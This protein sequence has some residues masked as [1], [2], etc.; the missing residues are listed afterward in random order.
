M[1]DYSLISEYNSK[2]NSDEVLFGADSRVLNT[3][4]NEMQE[5]QKEARRQLIQ[6]LAPSGFTVPIEL[7]YETATATTIK[8]LN[9]AEAYV[10]GMRIFIPKGTLIDL[11]DNPTEGIREDLLFLEVWRESANKDSVL[12]EFGGEGLPTVKNYFLSD[13]V[14]EETA[15]RILTKWRLRCIHD[16]DFSAEFQITNSIYPYIGWNDIYTFSKI[17]AKGANRDL[18]APTMIYGREIFRTSKNNSPRNEMWNY[19]TNDPNLWVAGAKNEPESIQRYK[20]VDGLVFG[21]PIARLN[22][23]AKGGIQ[24]EGYKKIHPSTDPTAFKNCVKAIWKDSDKNEINCIECFEGKHKFE[25]NTGGININGSKLKKGT[26]Y[27][28]VFN[29]LEQQIGGYNYGLIYSINYKDNTPVNYVPITRP[30]TPKGMFKL[31][32]EEQK[33]ILSISFYVH[34]GAPNESFVTVE[35]L[36]ILEGDWTGQDI[37][38]D[39]SIASIENRDIGIKL[40]GRTLQNLLEEETVPKITGAIEGSKITDKGDYYEVLFKKGQTY[41]QTVSKITTNIPLK[42]NTTYTILYERY[43]SE[44]MILIRDNTNSQNLAMGKTNTL[45]FVTLENGTEYN[46]YV[47][48][49]GSLANEDTILKRKKNYMILE[50][51]WTNKEIPEYFYNIQGASDKCKNLFN[52]ETLK[53]R[54]KDDWYEFKTEGNIRTDAYF[55]ISSSRDANHI[56]CN[57]SNTLKNEFTTTQ[58]TNYYCCIGVNGDTK[59]DKEWIEIKLKPNTKYIFSCNYYKEINL[60]KYKDIQIEEGTKAT[61][62][63]PYYEGEKVK[64]LSHGKNL[65]NK[66]NIKKLGESFFYEETF[67]FTG[68]FYITC[69]IT[70]PIY[71][72]AKGL[73][74]NILKDEIINNSGLYNFPLST[75]TLRIDFYNTKNWTQNDI[76]NLNLQVEEGTQATLYEPYRESKLE[77]LLPEGCG[78]NG[79]N[80]II[81]DTIEET[82][83]RLVYTKNIEKVV[84]NGSENWGLMQNEHSINTLA[85]QAPLKNKITN[86]NILSNRF[87]AIDGLGGQDIEG[88][89]YNGGDLYIRVLKTKLETQD[90]EGLKKYLQQNNITVYYQL[91]KPEVLEIEKTGE[92]YFREDNKITQDNTIKADLTISHKAN[93]ELKAFG[94][95][96]HIS[97]NNSMPPVF[98]VEE[99]VGT[100]LTLQNK[101]GVI[102]PRIKGR[103][104]QNLVTN[105]S[106]QASGGVIT[107]DIITIDNSA[108]VDGGI[109]VEVPIIKPNTRYT[110]IYAILENRNY[111]GMFQFDAYTIYP[112]AD[113]INLPVTKGL[114]KVAFNTKNTIEKTTIKIATTKTIPSK[115]SILK[116][117]KKILILEGDWTDKE[118]P[119]YFEGIKSVGEIEGNKISI[120]SNGKNYFNP[121][122]FIQ[123]SITAYKNGFKIVDQE[124]VTV[125]FNLK[126]KWTLS[127]KKTSVGVENESGGLIGVKDQN[128]KYKYTMNDLNDIV[129]ENG[130]KEIIIVNYCK[131]T[132]YLTDIQLEKGEKTPYEPY[133]EYKKEIQLQQPFVGLESVQDT[134]EETSKGVEYT[135]NIGKIILNGTENWQLSSMQDNNCITFWLSIPNIKENGEILSNSFNN[136]KSE[137]YNKENIFVYGA[138]KDIAIVILKSKL[139]TQDVAGFKKW[140]Q[141]NPI[142]VYYQLAEPIVIPLKTVLES[143]SGYGEYNL[144]GHLEPKKTENGAEE[145]NVITLP[146]SVSTIELNSPITFLAYNRDLSKLLACEW[147][148]TGYKINSVNSITNEVNITFKEQGIVTD[149]KF[150]VK[151]L[152]TQSLTKDK[153]KDISPKIKLQGYD[154]THLV[155]SELE[156]LLKPNK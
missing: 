154:F 97:S 96:T 128:G 64:Y 155:N 111:Q 61:P 69:N 57:G 134:I 131:G 103:T 6:S 139:E 98:E 121:N 54:L 73:N 115:D 43:S 153:V 109:M 12:T 142:T 123:K 93:I 91:A 21:L 110:I 114:N 129:S 25:K 44:D 81:Q 59:D 41:P 37:I 156:K 24:T 53:D 130:I 32:I 10:D 140:L 11:G 45:K 104:L 62:Y 22:R 72:K 23:R 51:D 63:E 36:S 78:F 47:S 151:G 48:R 119:N 79:L 150:K 112:T 149:K 39:N 84:L 40:Y 105:L 147:N 145:D 106:I 122:Y 148:T 108:V 89:T 133:K 92:L 65:F 49:V 20:T 90:I 95:V 126:G 74:G 152:V 135:Q 67:K 42:N 2:V 75:V 31:L 101:N 120:L 127:Y 137:I 4:L 144:A 27:T 107:G 28:L 26:K 94:E 30:D 146:D 87:I 66:N 34:S 46:F 70:K 9:D 118:I 58:Q 136:F 16:V 138:S 102:S 116:L 82:G 100:N 33:D 113:R 56:I 13:R 117:S 8:T 18:Q 88:M 60:I 17:Y 35:N 3:E 19:N 14:G 125:K 85:F 38:L 15:R 76:N 99:E 50:G 132:H 143:N 7:D 80:D 5:T 55:I 52:S 29:L 68:D 124:Q 83:K 77:Y 141:A 71:V 1:A 86:N